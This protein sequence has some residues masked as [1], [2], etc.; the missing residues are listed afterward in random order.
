VTDTAETVSRFPTGVHEMRTGT[1]LTL[2]AA[3]L[4][5]ASAVAGVAEFYRSSFEGTDGGWTTDAD[6]DV[7]GDWERGSPFPGPTPLTGCIFNV[8][9]PL[10]A[11][12]GAECWATRLNA[13]YTNANGTSFLRQTFDFTTVVNGTLAWQQY[14]HMIASGGSDLGRVRINDDVVYEVPF[15]NFP[16]NGWEP[17]S[18][19]LTP[20]SGLA[21]VEIVFEFFANTST[22]AAGWYLD[23]V[24]ITSIVDPNPGDV[25]VLLADDPDPVVRVGDPVT[26]TI[27][28]IN[29]SDAAATDVGVGGTLDAA[30]VFNALRSDPGVLHDGSP[31]GGGFSIAVGNMP[32]FSAQVYTLGADTTQLG[33]VTTMLQADALEPD[34]NSANDSAAETTSVELITDIAVRL[35]SDQNPVLTSTPFSYFVEVTNFGPSDATSTEWGLTLPGGV[36]FL[37][38]PD[39][40]HDGSPTGGVVSGKVPSLPVGA[41]ER[42]TVNVN[43]NPGSLG[44]LLASASAAVTSPD[45]NDPGLL[46]NSSNLTIRHVPSADPFARAILTSVGIELFVVGEPLPSSHPPGFPDRDYIFFDKPNVSPDGR[47]WGTRASLSSTTPSPENN[48]VIV[49][50]DASGPRSVVFEDVTPLPDVAGEF[51]SDMLPKLSINDAGCYAFPARTTGSR[52]NVIVKGCGVNVAGAPSL[53]VVARQGN[54]IPGDAAMRNYSFI[55]REPQLDND[56][57]VRFHARALQADSTT[58]EM[59]L[60]TADDGATVTVLIQEA[61]TVPTGQ[62]GGAMDP[63]DEFRSEFQDRTG[64]YVT[65]DGLNMLVRGDTTAATDV[66]DILALNNQVVTQAGATLGGFTSPI[67]DPA[68][69]VY[70]APNGDWYARGHNADGQGWV[71]RNGAVLAR[72]GDPVVPGSDIHWFSPLPGN[73]GFQLVAADANGNYA[74]GGDTDAPPD[75]DSF[76]LP[77]V[78]VLNGE[79]VLARTGDPIDLDG[80]GLFDHSPTIQVFQNDGAVFLENGTLVVNL[81]VGIPFD[82]AGAAAVASTTL[83]LDSVIAGIKVLNFRGACC[84]PDG[85]CL[86][87]VFELDCGAMGGQPHPNALCSQIACGTGAC[88]VVE[89]ATTAGGDEPVDVHCE[90]NVPAEQCLTD[91]LNE[92]KGNG[93]V[94]AEVTC[95]GA[96]CIDPD[97]TTAGLGLPPCVD[98]FTQPD[99]KDLGGDYQGDGTVCEGVLCNLCKRDEDCDDSDP[100]NGA[101]T[102]F[103][104]S[105]ATG[106][107]YC[108]NGVPP[109][110]NDGVDC[111]IDGCDPVTGVITHTPNHA[112]CDDGD[113][114]N[115]AEQ[116]HPMQGCVPGTPPTCDDGIGCTNDSC[117]TEHPDADPQTGCVN[118]PNDDKCD[119]GIDCTTDACNV[120][121]GLCTFT[122]NDD[123]CLDEN[124]CT[125][126]ERCDI[127]RGCLFD[128]VN[129]DDGVPC[130][131]DTCDPVI[132]CLHGADNSQCND[133]VSCTI[134]ACRPNHPERDANGCV[135]DPADFLCSSTDLCLTGRCDPQADCQFDP[136]ECPDDGDDCTREFCDSSTG[137]CLQET[138]CGACCREGQPCIDRVT[139]AQCSGPDDTFMGLGTNCETAPCGACC[140]PDSGACADG[141][142]ETDCA[143]AQKI[144]QGPGT[145]CTQDPCTGACCDPGFDDGACYDNLTAAECAAIDQ[146]AIFMGV[147]TDC[148]GVSCGACC[149]PVTSDRPQSCLDAATPEFCAALKFAYAGDQ[150]RCEDDPCRGACC[151]AD[152]TC[153]ITAPEDCD[154]D[155]R[156][157]GTSCIEINPPCEPFTGGACCLQ[158]GLCFDGTTRETCINSLVG[159]YAGDGVL[160]ESVLCPINGISPADVNEDGNIDMYDVRIITLFFGREVKPGGPGGRADIDGNGRVG[161]EDWAL[162]ARGMTGP[163]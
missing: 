58:D 4:P 96:C 37:S 48:E 127:D 15:D 70:L 113:P 45:E 39:G 152:G 3:S 153:R 89:Y 85:T 141:V 8:F 100:C 71:A 42:M 121:L 44:D 22:N 148:D 66:D 150:T 88:C 31:S 126:N 11:F 53:A 135:F 139:V 163:R 123:L 26:Y 128:P 106:G 93:S 47:T 62:A 112:A 80:N 116:C 27:T 51:V 119:D 81:A 134:D 118:T 72:T 61:S 78:L 21:S 154:G 10:A 160:C 117:D 6:W 111:T 7:V 23:D 151:R 24:A 63:W 110:T 91:R 130:T 32:A 115:G 161:Q 64:L 132:G 122:P 9:G 1:W 120:A 107:G 114:C 35:G 54:P 157:N 46:N 49:L 76:L 129:C 28:V 40:L 105:V 124:M 74:I 69:G 59:I 149:D 13:C 94:C 98:A 83:S 43:P 29:H 30:L 68:N 67:A 12:D 162:F 82:F 18:V 79:I 36:T 2:L 138:V 136:R 86:D 145:N 14:R 92:F 137:K 55:L 90:D 133:G 103:L 77:Q 97:E 101:E 75:P 143:Q 73:S 34:P 41:T 38:T 159:I 102:C 140:D 109:E 147:E 57:V 104:P 95:G 87:D 158:D 125:E 84:L 50:V 5:S 60:E 16:S 144:F 146:D 33:A 19:D 142:T 155:F 99:C 156:G 52:Q 56:G 20:Y 25:G 131:L 65:G 17:Q 108:L